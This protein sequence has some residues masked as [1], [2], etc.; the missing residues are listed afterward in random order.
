[1]FPLQGWVRRLQEFQSTIS[2]VLRPR[3][4]HRLQS[5]ENWLWQLLSI[6]GKEGHRSGQGS[7]PKRDRKTKSPDAGTLRKRCV[8]ET[9]SST[10]RLEQ[11]IAGMVAEEER[12]HVPGDKG[13]RT[14][15]WH[16][17]WARKEELLLYY[18]TNVCKEGRSRRLGRKM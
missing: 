9:E 8:E 5:M 12:G 17:L 7:Y 3:G 11:T 13:T 15:N 2:P 6:Q 1:M 4:E 18:V 16:R 14:Q 10:G